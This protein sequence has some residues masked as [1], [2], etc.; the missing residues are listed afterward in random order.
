MP[1]HAESRPEIFNFLVSASFKDVHVS[2]FGNSKSSLKSLDTSPSQVSSH[3]RRKLGQVWSPWSRVK[4]KSKVSSG[5]NGWNSKHLLYYYHS[6]LWN[7][8]PVLFV[9]VLALI[10]REELLAYWKK[11]WWY[12]WSVT[13]RGGSAKTGAAWVH[14]KGYR[15]LDTAESE[16]RKTVFSF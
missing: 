13:M 4:V 1:E 16:V 12:I 2:F 7:Q 5:C 9:G 15:F 10:R 3:C 11:C 8:S 14:Q 6:F